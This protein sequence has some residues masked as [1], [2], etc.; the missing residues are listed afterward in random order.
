MS[1]LTMF[2]S[3]KWHIA[4]SVKDKI[5]LEI[6]H[7]RLEDLLCRMS[8]MKMFVSQKWH[9]ADCIKEKVWVEMPHKISDF[10]V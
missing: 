2:V 7:K 1:C 4:A 5:S 9:V 10:I 3:Q 6:L 8:S